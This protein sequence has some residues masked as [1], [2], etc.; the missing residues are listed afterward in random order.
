MQYNYHLKTV[1]DL[2][3]SSAARTLHSSQSEGGRS[4]PIPAHLT[5]NPT[6]ATM[7]ETS[8]A[9]VAS[10]QTP[11]GGV[12]TPAAFLSPVNSVNSVNSVKKS[13]SHDAQKTGLANHALVQSYDA[14]LQSG[15][16]GR[17]AARVLGIKPVTIW[18]LHAKW[19]AAGRTIASVTPQHQN[20][21]RPRKHQLTQAEIKSVRGRMLLI[22]R[23]RT[24][25]STPEALRQAAQAGEL[26]PETKAIFDH[27]EATGKPLPETLLHDTFIP[28]TTTTSYRGARNAWLKYVESPGS[29]MLTVDAATGQERFWHPGEAWTIDD[30]TINLGVCVPLQ[31]PGDKCWQNFKVIVGRFQLIPIVDHMT[32]CIIGF[33]YTCRPKSSYRAEDLTATMQTTIA[34][35]G[36]PRVMFLEHGASASNL[37]KDTLKLLDIQ[38][39]Y[40][41]SPHQKVV[42]MLFDTIWIKLSN[43]PGQVGRFR[44]EMEEE[45][46]IYQACKEGHKD[47]RKHFPMLADLLQ[48]IRTAIEEINQQWVNSPQ[49]DRWQP[50]AWFAKDAGAVLRP[51]PTGSEWMFSP[52]VTKPLVVRRMAIGTSF[53]FMP[54]C[55]IKFHFAA[56]FLADL[57]GALV[58]LYYNPFAPECQATIVL[59]DD[60]HG[61]PAGTVLGPAQQ[62]N[63]HARFTRR[64]FGYG[65]DPDIGLAA[66]KQ[67]AQ[68]LRRHVQAI[69]PDGKPGLQSIE[70]RSFADHR[71]TETPAHRNT[72]TPVHRPTETPASGLLA[73]QAA[74]A[75]QLL[76]LS[77]QP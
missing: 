24:T 69:R 75:K 34:Q 64:A 9:D 14:L 55:T 39:I 2:P 67:H 57:P 68:E 5:L 27:C 74:R 11:A 26:T 62:I 3:S 65:Q 4:A 7:A 23:T 42:E 29:I 32:R 17:E 38:P 30:G 66:A 40:C 50:A 60:Y 51:V 10:P 52:C 28:E 13:P 33:S 36:A 1:N 21:G 48:A 12:S 18:R 59:A 37:V 54:G 73:R 58:K 15:L 44:G 56:S 76:A 71:T 53:C 31:R 70:T 22:N 25:S 47:P 45:G 8:T 35:H 16:S 46:K 6:Q 49:Y 63:R 19:L 77:E 41:A 43:L 72:E 20:A 61:K